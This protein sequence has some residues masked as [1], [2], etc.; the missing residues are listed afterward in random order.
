MWG[1]PETIEGCIRNS[2]WE[3]GFER[4]QFIW[5]YFQVMFVYLKP[6]QPD[7]N[8]FCHTFKI[9]PIHAPFEMETPESKKR[10]KVLVHFNLLLCL[11]FFSSLLRS[12]FVWVSFFPF[13][14]HFVLSVC[15]FFFPSFL[16]LSIL[17]F[18]FVHVCSFLCF[19]EEVP[20]TLAALIRNYIYIY[21]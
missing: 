1:D 3:K 9:F 16:M 10:L 8:L 21:I 17:P 20:P 11:S 2:I 5:F 14:L 7:V 15:L 18:S 6:K 12:S 13:C 4:L 19:F